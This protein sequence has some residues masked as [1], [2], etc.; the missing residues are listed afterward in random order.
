M[1]LNLLRALGL[2]L[3]VGSAFFLGRR[4]APQTQK[5]SDG[6]TPVI[7]GST[8]G[9][10]GDPGSAIAGKGPAPGSK[11]WVPLTGPADELLKRLLEARGTSENQYLLVRAVDEA[12]LDLLRHW[13]AELAAIPATRPWQPEALRAVA[14]RWAEI[15]APAALNWAQGL[16]PAVG[17]SALAAVLGGIAEQ[18]PTK[19]IS[20]AKGLP[21]G[22]ASSAA[23]LVVAGVLRKSDPAR[24][25]ASLQDLPAK[26]RLSSVGSLASSWVETDMEGAL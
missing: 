13:A 18:D 1:N 25:L 16:P 10:P 26:A 7:A 23:L 17:K 6:R 24:A 9:L 3:L 4:T 14:K 20:M 8:D 21:P 2:I 5:K 11:T 19:A 22:A 15:D 12:P